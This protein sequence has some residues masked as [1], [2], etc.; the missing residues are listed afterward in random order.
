MGGIRE[1]CPDLKRGALKAGAGPI[2]AEVLEHREL[3]GAGAGK[4]CLNQTV[5]RTEEKQQHPW[6]RSDR[7]RQGA[8]RE[9]GQAVGKCIAV[10]GLEE[11]ELSR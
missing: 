2:P 7:G 6:A 8:E 3:V 4:Q 9:V 1:P 10:G 11:L 5:L